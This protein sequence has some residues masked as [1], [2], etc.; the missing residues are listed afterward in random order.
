MKSLCSLLCSQKLITGASPEV[1][2]S[3]PDPH[4]YFFKIHLNII[5]PLH[6]GLL[7]G[8]CHPDSWTKLFYIFLISHACYSF[9][10]SSLVEHA[11]NIWWWDVSAETCLSEII[12]GLYSWKRKRHLRHYFPATG[13]LTS[14][15]DLIFNPVQICVI[16]LY[17]NWGCLR[18]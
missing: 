12:P 9:H 5:L 11:N 4:V 8:L 15:T 10:L 1:D 7:S 16:C 2:E 3:S 17:L 14:C 18:T 13:S 6:V